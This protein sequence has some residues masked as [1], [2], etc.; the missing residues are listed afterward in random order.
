MGA[1]LMASTWGTSWGTSWGVSW[2]VNT[3]PSLT[4]Y[5]GVSFPLVTHFTG[6]SRPTVSNAGAITTG[7]SEMKADNVIKAEFL[8]NGV[9]P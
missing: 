7:V 8:V 6:I 3:G 9:L 1:R 2:E 4:M 5:S